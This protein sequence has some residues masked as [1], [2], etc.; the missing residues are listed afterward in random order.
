MYRVALPP[1][2]CGT[3]PTAQPAPR[4]TPSNPQTPSG[5]L[6]FDTPITGWFAITLKASNQFSMYLFDG[7]VAGISSI[8]YSTLG[9]AVNNQ[10]KA[11]NLSHASLWG[12]SAVAAPVPEPGTYAL[13]FAGLAVV[14]WMSRRHAPR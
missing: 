14:G 12:G 10:G 4:L 11:Q 6:S 2:C 7:G 3:R 1:G 8:D 5:T 9:T 13:F